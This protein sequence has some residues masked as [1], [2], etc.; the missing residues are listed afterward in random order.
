MTKA[1]LGT[2]AL[3]FRAT[4]LRKALEHVRLSLAS[5]APLDEVLRAAIAVLT[6]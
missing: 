1:I 3:A 5:K 2:L 4:D 6:T